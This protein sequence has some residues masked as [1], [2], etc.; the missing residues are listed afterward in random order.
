MRASRPSN[1]GSMLHLRRPYAVGLICTVL[2]VLALMAFLFTPP[3]PEDMSL[4]RA[5]LRL[6]TWLSVSWSMSPHD[7]EEMMKLTER[8][9]A[10]AVDDVYVYVSYL[11]PEGA[12][13]PT[14]GFAREFVAALKR[15]APELRALAW[16]GVPVS[17]EGVEPV[18]RLA[19]AEIRRTIADFSRYAVEDL[20]FAGLHLNAE[21]VA[22]GD[23][24]LLETLAEIRDAMPAHAILSATAHPLRLQEPVTFMPYPAVAH[25]WSPAYFQRVA[26][27][28]DQIVLMAYDSGLVFPRDYLNWMRYQVERSQ[29]ALRND[30]TELIIGAS[31][32]AEWTLSHQT[33]AETLR[34]ALAGMKM[35]LSERLDG[36][37]IYPVWE[38]NENESKLIARS[39]GR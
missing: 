7:A 17:V 33:Q 26:Q 28:V 36:I 38:T 2:L 14:F 8:L 15:Y 23:T 24:W 27:S 34:L 18:N 3:L 16:V 35:G 6:S 25:H 29:E 12:F 30:P 37:A 19:S 32:S 9:A 5:D 21:L 20:G 1:L 4:G 13:N 11:K 10:L 39:L 31:L 22:D